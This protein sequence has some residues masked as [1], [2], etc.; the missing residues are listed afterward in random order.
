MRRSPVHWIAGLGAILCGIGW[1]QVVA[2]SDGEPVE[3]VPQT[4]T[5][6]AIDTLLER[7]ATALRTVNYEGTL[8]Y[9]HDNRLETLNLL[10]RVEQGQIQERLISLTGPLR[11]VTQAHDRVMCVLPDGH[12]ISI[13]RQG[14]GRILGVGGINPV[15]LGKHYRIQ[16]A[17]V[18]RVAGRETDVVAIVPRDHLRYGYR[19]HIDRETALPLKSDLIDQHEDPLEQ[20]MFT[21]I[22]FQPSDGVAPEATFEP[23][24]R[25]APATQV[26]ASSRWRFDNPPAGFQLVMHRD[27]PQSDGAPAEHFLFTDPL[28]AYSIYVESGAQDGL[29]EPTHI[30]A[31]HAIGR[32]INGYQVTVVGEV[33]AATVEAAIAGVHRLPETTD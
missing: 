26:Q 27:M 1:I 33:P 12:P 8:V 2:A 32:K 31:V 25:S 5:A 10:H 9:L 24:V 20:L 3:P 14:G 13:E 7:M 28:S 22:S 4:A 21:T 15:L 18:A 19:F 6:P 11:A 30:G 29:D 16:S 23:S 17:G